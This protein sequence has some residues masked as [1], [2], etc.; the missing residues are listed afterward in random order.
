MKKLLLGAISIFVI[1][2][3]LF[4]ILFLPGVFIV[5]NWAEYPK[6]PETMSFYISSNETSISL[7]GDRIPDVQITEQNIE[8][9][10]RN[11]LIE[12]YFFPDDA[13]FRRT[14][15]EYIIV[16]NSETGVD[17]KIFDGFGVS[18][19]REINNIPVGPADEINIRI[20]QDGTIT[21]GGFIGWRNYTEAG[22]ATMISPQ[23][24]YDK[25]LN[26]EDIVDEP[27]MYQSIIVKEIR[28]CYYFIHDE[29]ILIPVWRFIGDNWGYSV[30]GYSSYEYRSDIK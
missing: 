22:E 20:T 13:V 7:S 16:S 17:K 30:K 28:L 2:G 1:C 10:V 14:S 25:L 26:R 21:L 11:Y 18:Y 8:S 4:Y 3:L 15:K 6:Y 24:A 29:H 19:G 27:M 5:L 9:I 12:N 23:Q